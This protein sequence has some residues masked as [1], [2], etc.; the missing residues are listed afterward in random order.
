MRH[1][2]NVTVAK[3]STNP[4]NDISFGFVI[5]FASIYGVLKNYG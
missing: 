5:W 3:A 2:K 4:T 1:I